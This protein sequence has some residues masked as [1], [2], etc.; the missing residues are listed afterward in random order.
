MTAIGCLISDKCMKPVAVNCDNPQL[1]G[2]WLKWNVTVCLYIRM[3][4]V[5]ITIVNLSSFFSYFLWVSFTYI[6]NKDTSSLIIITQMNDL[7][8]LKL[9]KTVLR[10]IQSEALVF[11]LVFKY[12][13]ISSDRDFLVCC[14]VWFYHTGLYTDSVLQFFVHCHKSKPSCY[15]FM[16]IFCTCE[17]P[18]P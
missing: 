2:V 14:S 3:P 18:S 11:R 16:C 1:Y 6:E 7:S 9:Y 8:F 5:F 17:T 4:T 12:L 10:T 13:I 15:F